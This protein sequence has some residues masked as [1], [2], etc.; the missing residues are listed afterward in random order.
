MALP[1]VPPIYTVQAECAECAEAAGRRVSQFTAEIASAVLLLV[2]LAH[3]HTGCGLFRLQL[4]SR[5]RLV[6]G[7]PHCRRERL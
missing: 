7:S 2:L 4:M 6:R 3:I 1:S 5:E